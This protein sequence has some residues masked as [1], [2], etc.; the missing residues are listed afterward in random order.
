MFL[1]G[2]EW[3][4]LWKLKNAMEDVIY[5]MERYTW[6]STHN[7]SWDFWRETGTVFDHRLSSGPRN[8]S[9]P[10]IRVLPDTF[11][12]MQNLLQARDDFVRER[13][14]QTSRG[15]TWSAPAGMTMTELFL[16]LTRQRDCRDGRDRIYGLLGSAPNM[17]IAPDYTLNLTTVFSDF[18]SRFLE[19]EDF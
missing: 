17:G 1:L 8:S 15:S 12:F 18:T 2:D 11:Q 19:S 7:I 13:R 16:D 10:P 3:I 5:K 9:P 4:P 6:V 14:S